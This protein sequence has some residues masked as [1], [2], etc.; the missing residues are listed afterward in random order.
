MIIV[1]IRKNLMRAACSVLSI[2][3][4]MIPTNIITNGEALESNDK[5]KSGPQSLLIICNLLGIEADLDEL[6][7]LSGQNETGTTTH[8][9]RQ[10]AQKKGLK[11]VEKRLTVDDLRKCG[12]PAIAVVRKYER[13]HFIVVN[14]FT[15]DKVLINDFS[16]APSLISI[17]EFS[18]IFDGYALIISKKEN[19]GTEPGNPDIDFEEFFHDFGQA[20]QMAQV[21]HTF[22]FRNTGDVPLVILHIRKS[23]KCTATMLSNKEVLAGGEGYIRLSFNTGRSRGRRT[24]TVVIH[25]ND[26]DEPYIFLSITGIVKPSVLVV[27]DQLRIGRVL[28]TDI[29]SQTIEVISADEVE[30]KILRLETSSDLIEAKIISENQKSHK[31]AVISVNFSS[32]MPI[33]KIEEKLTIYTDSKKAPKIEVPIKGIIV[34]EIKVLPELLFFGIIKRGKAE[35]RKVEISKEGK[36]DLEI[37]SVEVPAVSASARIIPIQ[38]GK[39]YAIEVTLSEDVQAGTIRDTV[40]IHTNNNEQPIISVPLCALIKS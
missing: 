14:D 9:L 40:K 8:G 16:D 21:Y 27:P 3:F 33:G 4:L 7:R 19:P 13:S 5:S 1:S 24:E 38:K 6:C 22:R 35:S 11:A 20:D 29:I 30:M 36:K 18:D 25:S 32:K 17:K 15:S 31:R 23:C 26:A 10:A 2:C 37:I 34:G 12:K 28:S 39:K